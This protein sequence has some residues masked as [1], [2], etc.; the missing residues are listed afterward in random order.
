MNGYTKGEW[1]VSNREIVSMPSQVK[2][3]GRIDGESYEKAKAN[4]RLISAAPDLLRAAE[5]AYRELSKYD[6]KIAQ[7]KTKE[8]E[9]AI[10]KAKGE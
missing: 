1:M 8:L 6:N 5:R 9:Q 7:K 3:T 10:N 2:I 4:A